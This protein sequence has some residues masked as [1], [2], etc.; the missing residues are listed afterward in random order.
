MRLGL[1]F[2]RY[3]KR[4]LVQLTFLDR[5]LLQDDLNS[6][7]KHSK[8]ILFNKNSILQKNLFCFFRSHWALQWIIQRKILNL[9]I[10]W[11]RLCT[12]SRM[13]CYLPTPN[14]VD[15][16]ARKTL[17]SSTHFWVCQKTFSKVDKRTENSQINHHVISSNNDLDLV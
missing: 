4:S 2:R 9:S 15:P 7:E 3:L 16:Q 1:V 6:L 17:S 5:Y 14:Y 8:F 13:K 10:F 11:P 12:I